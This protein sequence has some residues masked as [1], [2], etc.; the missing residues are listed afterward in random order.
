MKPKTNRKWWQPER[1]NA[2]LELR[3]NG[4]TFEACAKALQ[5]SRNAAI[6]RYHRLASREHAA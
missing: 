5:I 3:S 6:A 1:D 4:L 2:L